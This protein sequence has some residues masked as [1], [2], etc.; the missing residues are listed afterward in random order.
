MEKYKTMK[1]T[2]VAQVQAQLGNLQEVDA[3]ELGEVVDMIKDLEEAMYYCSIVK[4]M[5]GKDKQDKDEEY[6]YQQRYYTDYYPDHHDKMY[7][8]YYRDL[9]RPRG[10]MYDGGT[11]VDGGHDSRIMNPMT[12]DEREGRSP[13][14]RKSYMEGKELHHDKVYQMKELEQYMKELSSD[15]TEMITDA[16]PEEKQ[17]L[18]QKIETLATKIV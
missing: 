5:E 13:R 11:P 18:K 4:A 15:I 12:R 16:T 2:L 14:Y 9:D 17:L 3:K 1:D 10:K 8:D 7:P 6:R